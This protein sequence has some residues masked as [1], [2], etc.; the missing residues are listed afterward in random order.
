MK[1]TEFDFKGKKIKYREDGRFTV[2]KN[3]TMKEHSNFIKH[4]IKTV[5]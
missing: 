5:K 3:M 2:P 4:I 1:E